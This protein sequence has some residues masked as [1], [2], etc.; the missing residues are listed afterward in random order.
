MLTIPELVNYCDSSYAKDENKC[1][2]CTNDEC[3]GAC[4]RCFTEIHKVGNMRDYDCSNLMYHYVCTYIY[5]YSSE[6]WHLF[7][8]DDDLKNLNEYKV[9]S[10]GCGPASELFGISK[11]ANGKNVEYIGF[12]INDRWTD[13]H[14]KI[15]EIVATEENC[16]V[17]LKMGDVFDQFEGLNFMPN[18]IVLSYLISHLS[19]NNIDVEQFMTDL[20]DKILD[21]LDKPYFIIMNDINLNTAHD[22]FPIIFRKLQSTEKEGLSRS[23]YYFDGYNYGTRHNSRRLI[24]EIPDRILTKYDTWRRCKK[25][26]Q[27][28]IK[29]K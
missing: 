13:I 2:G 16:T 5:A 6:I 18:V 7:N 11:I 23:C 9:L 3:E 14:D 28:L 22:N 12:D 24:E 4:V 8:T 19:K 25:T 21:I 27:M 17:E 1:E 10:I 15:N 29:V 26:A 20:K